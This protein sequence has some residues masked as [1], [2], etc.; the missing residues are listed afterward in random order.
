MSWVRTPENRFPTEARRQW[1]VA[2]K[3]PI[4]PRRS[5]LKLTTLA[6][7]PL[8]PIP[9]SE[10]R[11]ASIGCRRSRS[12]SRALKAISRCESTI[13]MGIPSGRWW[14]YLRSISCFNCLRTWF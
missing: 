2:M 11:I 5:S 4:R 8:P 6:P 12:H 3:S 10:A 7:R 9:A 13:S 1:Q 14:D